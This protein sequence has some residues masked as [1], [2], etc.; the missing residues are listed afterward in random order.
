MPVQVTPAQLSLD[1]YDRS[2]RSLVNGRR[3]FGP[4]PYGAVKNRCERST[5][6][7]DRFDGTVTQRSDRSAGHGGRSGTDPASCWP[8]SCSG[9]A[10]GACSSTKEARRGDGTGQPSST[11]GS[12]E[13]FEAIG[14]IDRF[15]GDGV[16]VRGAR[17]RSGG[18]TLGELNL[19]S[20]A[21]SYGFD[22]GISEE[23]TESVLTDYLIEQGGFVTR[24][25]RLIGLRP[26]PD[27]V[28]AEIDQ[29]GHRSE[30]SLA[31]VVG[32]DGFRSSVRD[33]AGIDF[34][35]TEVESPW[36]VFDAATQGWRED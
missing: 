10:S 7:G 27:G 22:I 5:T 26:G 36:A 33:L 23:V 12:L 21:S 19:S 13:I 29:N 34:L 16:K 14:V 17:F 24:S 25:T 18:Q 11:P 15:L 28:T 31:W 3:S 32:C 8:Q 1:G 4:V 9:A 6:D 20:E 30:V 2:R 35:G